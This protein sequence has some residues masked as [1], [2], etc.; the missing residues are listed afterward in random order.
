VK[1]KCKNKLN[2]NSYYTIRLVSYPAR[3]L[4]CSLDTPPF[5]FNLP[6]GTWGMIRHS[7]AKNFYRRG[8]F[9]AEVLG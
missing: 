9:Q 1:K 2:Y 8:V 7:V 5:I 3:W 6:R 4:I